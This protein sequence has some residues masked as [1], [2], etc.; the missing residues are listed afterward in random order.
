VAQGFGGVR[1]GEDG[2]MAQ[3]AATFG[4]EETHGIL[5][6]PE[7]RI[8]AK[9]D[10]RGW[11]SLYASTQRETPYEAEY[12]A[13]QDHLIILHLDGPVGVRRRLGSEESHR[14]VP[15]GGLFILPGG[16]DFGVE[17]EGELDSL[18]VYLRRDLVAEVADD[19][20]LEG[21]DLALTPRLGERDLLIER[22][23]LGVR[24]AL[25][26]DDAAA[27]VYVDYLSRALAARLLREHSNCAP[28][29]AGP[30][31]GGLTAVQMALA[32]DFMEAQLDRPLALA[33]IA[34]ACGLSPT[35]FA[36]L[37][38][39]TAGAPP[40]QHLM[41]L[42]VERAK[43][44]L[45]GSLPIVEVALAC[46]FTHQEHLTRVFRRMTGMTPASFRRSA[47]S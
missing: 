30:P 2:Q 46:G 7:N 47:Q 20:G 10:G 14:I 15:P 32:S 40:H 16:V 25:T 18:H 17:L 37:F 9:S 35:H 36:R 8:Y 5:W 44:L 31:T 23:A 13:V 19:L 22:L 21:S 24:E 43:R 33:D 27:G 42:R 26:D 4:V 1:E 28:E 3:A 29:R 34:S 38:K 39:V 41:H 12:P 6:R 45:Q 11:S